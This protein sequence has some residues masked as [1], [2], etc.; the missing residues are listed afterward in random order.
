MIKL[1]TNSN[2]SISHH[3]LL[4]DLLADATEVYMATAFLKKAAINILLPFFN[5]PIRFKI[6]AGYNFGITDPE[7]LTTLKVHAERSSLISGYLVNMNLKQVFHP[8]LYLIKD[9]EYCHIISGSANMT[10]GGLNVNNE[11]SLYFR[12]AGDNPMWLDSLAY[13]SDCISPAKADLL[14]ER[15]IAIYRDYHKKQKKII[16]QAEEFPDKTGSLIY[17]LKKLKA[18]Y[19]KLD[20]KEI[21]AGFKKKRADYLEAKEVLDSIADTQHTPAQFKV[22]VEDMVGKA[23][24]PGLWYSN[25]MFRLKTGLFKQQTGF[26]KL[27][28]AIRSNKD[29]SPSYI[30]QIA[31]DITKSIKGV[32]PNFI[33]EIMMTYAPKKLANINQNPITVLREEGGMDI[34]A[35]SSSYNGTDYEEYSAIIREIAEKLGLKDMLEIDYFFNIV[36][37]KIKKEL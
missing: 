2:A 34:K 29:K 13:F 26:R 27:I 16:V 36:Y 11:V 31:K 10:N 15:I 17:N 25:G 24:T 32:G 22:L 21:N 1:I 28:V 6:I 14:S 19:T 9:R 23:G 7:A 37:Q 4:T 18:H 3:Q 12:C 30:Y 5:K 8:K 35:Y 33:G 20:Q